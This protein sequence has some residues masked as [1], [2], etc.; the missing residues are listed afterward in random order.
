MFSEHL[1]SMIKEGSEADIIGEAL[2]LYMYLLGLDVYFRKLGTSM[3]RQTYEENF[4]IL[5]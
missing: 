2:V 5:S 3:N 1:R 4:V